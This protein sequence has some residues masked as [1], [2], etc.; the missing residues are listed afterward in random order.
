MMNK[1]NYHFNPAEYN[2]IIHY[3][4]TQ[5]VTRV[6][7]YTVNEIDQWLIDPENEPYL[8]KGWTIRNMNGKFIKRG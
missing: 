6:E 3:K 8:G 1:T 4:G 7:R 5:H 2:L